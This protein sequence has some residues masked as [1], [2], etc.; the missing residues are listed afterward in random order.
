[1]QALLECIRWLPDLKLETSLKAISFQADGSFF[2]GPASSMERY[3][4]PVF[5][6]LAT[7]PSTVATTLAL[8]LLLGSV[9]LKPFEILSQ[10]LIQTQSIIK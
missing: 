8:T 1:M 7:L 2:V 9:T 4:D 5:H 3:M 6:L 10:N